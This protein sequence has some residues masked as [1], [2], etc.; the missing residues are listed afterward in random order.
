MGRVAVLLLVLALCQFIAWVI[1]ATPGA[2]GIEHYLPLHA[3]METVAIVI[4]MMVFMVGWN[5]HGEKTSGNL[6]L[7]SCLFFAIGWLDFS[8]TASYSGMPDF[9][10][11]N[12]PDKQLNFWIAARLLAAIALL[13]VALRPWDRGIR[14]YSKYA[15]LIALMLGVVALNW[16]VIHDQEALPDLFI[17]GQGLTP[18][19]KNLEYACIAINLI[20]MLLLWTKMRTTQ[21]FN[22][23][24]LFA[25]AAVMAMSEFYFTLYTTMTGAYNVLGHVY[26]VI[27]YLIIYRAV[28]V[29]S[30]ERPYLQLAQ[31]RKN[32]ALAVEASTTGMIMV[33][34]EGRI[35]LTNAQTDTMFGYPSGA[36]VGVS[37]QALIPPAQREQHALLVQ[38]YLHGPTERKMGEGRELFGR[39]KLGHD[40]RVEIGLTPISDEGNHYVIA[41]IVDVTTRVEHEQR[42]NQLIYFD[43]LTGL[44]NRTLLQDRVSQAIRTASRVNACLAIFFLDLDHFKNVNDS[45]G[46]ST[47]DDLLVAVGERLKTSVRESDTVARLGGDEF[48][49]A[50]AV[51]DATDAAV[52]AIKLQESL[53]QPYVIGPHMLVA[54]P[55]IGIAM[56]PEDGADFAVLYQ[57]A[58]TAMY[59]A[60][61]DGRNGYRF[62]TKKMHSHTER[63]LTLGNAMHKALEQEQFYLNYQPQLSVDGRRV[64]GVEALLRWLH[65]TLGMISPAEFIPLAE[66]NGQIISI[67]TW[68][69]RTAVRQ[70]RA[71][72]DAGLPPMVMAVNLSAVQFR[73]PNLPVLVTQILEEA[74]L[75]PHYLELE[76]TEGVTMGDPQSAIGVMD[77][78]HARGVRMSIDDFGT[79]YSSLSYLKKFKIYKLKIDQSFVRDIATDPDDRAIVTAIVEMSHSLGFVAIAEGVET[80][81]QQEFLIQNGCDEVQGYLFSKPLPADQIAQFV[82]HLAL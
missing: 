28:V 34:G 14:K 82:K 19:K 18:L 74:A 24:L 15:L 6:V 73:Q 60:K 79:G 23:P 30:I 66:S 57:H 67:G 12:G 27:S 11:H 42:I 61:E 36:L 41:S 80:P 59:Q 71:W 2:S 26:K 48:V 35:T 21:T 45:L 8:H 16:V 46:H 1:P 81:A 39:H 7:L 32:L 43:P 75:P 33:D 53:S 44:P 17:P 63:M 58:D 51:A 5:S 52:I 70:L 78:L 64:V 77:E 55:S 54:T 25:A 62:F 72:M 65:P 40:F 47:G 56:Y 50:L 68:V 10:S 38:S 22:A 3:L 76:L 69:L 20:T 37:I 31:T 29:E 4:A 13:L 49:I 9:V